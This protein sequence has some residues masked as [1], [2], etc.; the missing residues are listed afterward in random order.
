[1]PIISGLNKKRQ[2][3]RR[4]QMQPLCPRTWNPEDI[5]KLPSLAF[6]LFDDNRDGIISVSELCWVAHLGKPRRQE[7][8]FDEM[9]LFSMLDVNGD[10]IISRD[11]FCEIVRDPALLNEYALASVAKLCKRREARFHFDFFLNR[12][13]ADIDIDDAQYEEDR[14]HSIT[15]ALGIVQGL[16]KKRGASYDDAVAQELTFEESSPHQEGHQYDLALDLYAVEMRHDF[17]W[18]DVLHVFLPN[19]PPRAFVQVLTQSGTRLASSDVV[20]DASTA[21]KWTVRIS[22]AVL[23]EKVPYFAPTKPLYVRLRLYN[24]DYVRGDACL[25]ETPVFAVASVNLANPADEAVVGPY[26]VDSTD[27]MLAANV[28][29]NRR[30]VSADYCDYDTAIDIPCAGA[31]L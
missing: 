20:V 3:P 15:A 28:L 30:W 22:F 4:R 8:A 24:A 1:M 12:S 27:G 23:Q 11:E 26:P 19:A 17:A 29:G 18:Y 10:S 21:A 6:D 5:R 9:Q 13:K 7:S 2:S 25:G 16:K 14:Y 31:C